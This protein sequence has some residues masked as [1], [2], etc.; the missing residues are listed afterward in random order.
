MKYQH[1]C[2][3]CDVN[4]TVFSTVN[5]FV[6]TLCFSV[7]RYRLLVKNNFRAVRVY[8]HS[9]TQGLFV[10]VDSLFSWQICHVFTQDALR[11]IQPVFVGLLINFFNQETSTTQEEAFLYALA[12]CLCSLLSSF[13][14]TPFT[15][16]RQCYGMRVRVACT[17][18]VY[19]K[20]NSAL[21]YFYIP[22]VLLCIFQ[23]KYLCRSSTAYVTRFLLVL[24]PPSS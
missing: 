6:C 21:R 9:K 5:F 8:R 4:D 13:L 15:F 24:S 23:T 17:S 19:N 1:L 2:T 20:V 10:L 12:V 16:L 18:L 7:R 22:D 14:M 11:I 3:I